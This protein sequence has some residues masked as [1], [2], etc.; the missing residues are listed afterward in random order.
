MTKYRRLIFLIA[1][2][3]ILNG[4]VIPIKQWEVPLKSTDTIARYNEDGLFEIWI[5]QS[6][7][8][9]TLDIV[10]DQSYAVD[11]KGKFYKV[12][13][14]EKSMK[15]DKKKMYEIYLYNEKINVLESFRNGVWEL[16]IHLQKDHHVKIRP[17]RFK[18]WTFYYT[19][20]IH[21]A[22]N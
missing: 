4:C 8:T 21:G 13:S 11:P 2:V 9:N 7:W 3:L 14:E 5:D 6:E 22:P 18:L 10:D 15:S 1:I 16:S 17:F 19:P 12:L 20:L